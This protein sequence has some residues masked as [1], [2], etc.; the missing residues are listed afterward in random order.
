[1]RLFFLCGLL[2]LLVTPSTE[3]SQGSFDEA[4]RLTNAGAYGAALEAAEGEEDALRRAQ[5][6]LHV[7][8]QAGDL[9]G[10]LGA[11]QAGLDDFPSDLW[12]LEQ[13]TQLALSL[14][15]VQL[16]DELSERFGAQAHSTGGADLLARASSV[17]EQVS[18][19]VTARD[20]RE[21]ALFRA[22]LVSILLFG[23]VLI[24]MLALGRS[25][26]QAC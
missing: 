18:L 2:P 8:W 20:G 5:A 14:H 13:G 24:A 25:S 7:R 15:F 9:R 21:T 26:R 23:F 1:M 3:G 4:L 6:T 19:L 17:A 12:L 10:A 22:R 16:A 11:A